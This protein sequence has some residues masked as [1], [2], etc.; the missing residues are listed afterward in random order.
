MT[1]NKVNHLETLNN[2]RNLVA[3]VRYMVDSEF[4]DLQDQIARYI[5]KIEYEDMEEN[6]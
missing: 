2:F 5:L 3:K 6:Q 4:C 1:N